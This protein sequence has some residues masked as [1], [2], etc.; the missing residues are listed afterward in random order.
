MSDAQASFAIVY[1]PEKFINQLWLVSGSSN[2]RWN[3]NKFWHK[4][5]SAVK[6]NMSVYLIY[7]DFHMSGVA[8][9]IEFPAGSR[10]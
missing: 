2:A 9:S 7:F 8:N 10:K 4:P 5:I 6:M 1:T 3:W